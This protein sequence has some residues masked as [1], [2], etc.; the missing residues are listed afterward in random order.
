VKIRVF[1]GP[2]IGVLKDSGDQR[3]FLLQM[4][5]SSKGFWWKRRETERSF[6]EGF[7]WKKREAK[8]SFGFKFVIFCEGFWVLYCIQAKESVVRRRWDL[9]VVG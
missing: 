2:A 9:R 3:L 7:R 6:G 4:I 1:G 8:K 5:A